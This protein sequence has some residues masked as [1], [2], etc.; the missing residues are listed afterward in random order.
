M[1]IG[2]MLAYAAVGVAAVAAA[3]FTGGGSILA[4][5]TAAGSLAGAG[6]LAAGAGIVGAGVG[7]MMSNSEEEKQKKEVAK[8][9]IKVN[10]ATNIV[11]EYE[12]HTKLVIA[13]TALGAS[14][15]NIDGE[16]SSEEQEELNEYV[17]GLASASY[18]EIV[19]EKI[20][21]ILENPP[22]FNEAIEHLKEVPS[23]EYPEI[24]NLLVSVMEADGIQHDKEKA[25]ISA[26]DAHI[27][28]EK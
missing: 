23:V 21:S 26:F 8:A 22:T 11:K 5:T 9:N 1:G 17:G 24:R 28:T 27:A 25:F 18:P 7:K 3:P 16:I 10:K 4:A 14:M 13:L 15:A 19:L 6:T 12:I 20:K 2:K